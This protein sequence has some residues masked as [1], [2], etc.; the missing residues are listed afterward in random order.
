MCACVSAS[1]ISL[2]SHP[3]PPFLFPAKIQALM[4]EASVGD[5]DEE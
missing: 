3:T 4:R 5:F 1:D 2:S